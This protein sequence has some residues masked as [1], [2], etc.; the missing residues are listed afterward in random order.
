MSCRN[1]LTDD[2]VTSLSAVL[3]RQCR[4]ARRSLRKSG[5]NTSGF[6]EPQGMIKQNPSV[7]REGFS[8]HNY[9]SLA[10]EVIGRQKER[11]IHRSGN[12]QHECNTCTR[13]MET[14]TRP[15]SN[16]WLIKDTTGRSI[17][18]SLN[19]HE[20]QT[21]R[22]SSKRISGRWRCHR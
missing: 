13:R 12:P 19:L 17:C 21:L 4:N 11:F 14:L 2:Q 9:D 16:S 20:R 8:I 1:W 18:Q 10:C 6:H 22:S 7:P 3:P 15:L 5:N